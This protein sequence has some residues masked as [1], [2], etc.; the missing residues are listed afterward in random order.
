MSTQFDLVARET[1]HDALSSDPN[2]EWQT[3]RFEKALATL[4]AAALAEQVKLLERLKIQSRHLKHSDPNDGNTEWAVPTLFID[5]A[6]A[7]LK[8]GENQ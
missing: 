3:P 1:L 6:L 8:A 2:N 5:E 4:T 7:A